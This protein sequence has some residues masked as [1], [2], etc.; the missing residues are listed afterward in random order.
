MSDD[1]ELK[2]VTQ[3]LLKRTKEK[4]LAETCLNDRYLLHTATLGEYLDANLSIAPYTVPMEEMFGGDLV[5]RRP[6][7]G[8]EER[9][10]SLPQSTAAAIFTLPILIGNYLERIGSRSQSRSCTEAVRTCGRNVAPI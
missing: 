1:V 4:Q 5:L 6:R 7:V 9:F 8:R 10:L 3:S 2:L